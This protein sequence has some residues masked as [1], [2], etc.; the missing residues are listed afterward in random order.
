MERREERRIVSGSIGGGA[1][2]FVGWKRKA[3]VLQLY[4]QEYPILELVALGDHTRRD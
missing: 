2:G 3:P 4:V 1:V